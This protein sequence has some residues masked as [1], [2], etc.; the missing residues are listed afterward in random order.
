MVESKDNLENKLLKV[1]ITKMFF[2]T[3]VGEIID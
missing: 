1:K 3:L 2:D